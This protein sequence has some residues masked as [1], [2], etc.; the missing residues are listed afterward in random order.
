MTDHMTDRQDLGERE[1]LAAELRALRPGRGLQAP[2]AGGKIGPVLARICA[3][4]PERDPGGA[5]LGVIGRI[6]NALSALP[7]DLQRALR[8]AFALEP[9][10]QSRFLTERMAWLAGQIGRDVRT[11]AR[12]VESAF[13]LLADVLLAQEARENELLPEAEVLQQPAYAEINRFAPDGWYVESFGATLRMHIDPVEILETRRGV[14]TRDGLE[15]VTVAWSIPGDIEPV[16]SDLRVDMIYGGDLRP[17]KSLSTASYWAGDVHLP[18]PLAAGETFEFQ[19]RVSSLPKAAVRPFF[20][21]SPYRRCDEFV[22][23]AT[24]DRDAPPSEV[25]M[26]DGVPFQLVDENQPVGAILE[27]DQFCE[28]EGRYSFLRSGLSY[29]LRW[30]FN[31]T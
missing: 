29:G 1:P 5:R 25:W 4:D 24:F 7:T 2:E 6:Q 3:A 26:L 23:R 18:R 28:V 17:D 21:L 9:A 15:Q 30:R 12:Q 19:V 22:L 13:L 31:E 11:A 20:V 8:A 16:G 27:L 10:D 14:S